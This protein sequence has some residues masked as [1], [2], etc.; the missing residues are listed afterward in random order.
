M[1]VRKASSVCPE[2]VRR[3]SFS[4]RS[5]TEIRSGSRAFP[6]ASKYSSM[7]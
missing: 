2:G 7:A 4:S 3:P 5:S 1:L 6:A